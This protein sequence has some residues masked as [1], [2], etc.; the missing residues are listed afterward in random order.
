M[1]AGNVFAWDFPTV[2][3]STTTVDSKSRAV[4]KHF[5]PGDVLQ[6]DVETSD[7]IVLRRM[8][9]APRG[10]KRKTGKRN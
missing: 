7:V 9:P 2:T 5:L 6:I 4:V 1:L 3:I 8:K 10:K